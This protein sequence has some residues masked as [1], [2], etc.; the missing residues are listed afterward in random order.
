MG[1]GTTCLALLA[2]LGGPVPAPRVQGPAVAGAFYPADAQELAAVVDRLLAQAPD[3]GIPGL[4]ALVCP[5]AGYAFSGPVAAA[6]Y[7]QVRGRDFRRAI[8]LGPSHY[9][10]F[11]GAA[12]PGAEAC[13]TPLGDLRIPPGARDWG[14]PI[15]PD[16]PCRV[17]APAWAKAEARPTPFTYE[18]SVEVQLPFLQKVLPGC[19]VV[20]LLLGRT[21]PAALARTLASHVDEHTLVIASSDLSHY[22]T[23][24]RGRSLDQACVA[25]ICDLD[26]ARMARQEACGKGPILTLLHL[27]RRMGWK[28]RLLDLRSSGD[29]GAGRDSVVG[30]AAIAF[31]DP[32]AARHALAPLDRDGLSPSERALLLDLARRSLRAAAEGGPAPGEPANLT[33][34]LREDRGC[35][36]TLTRRGELRGCIGHIRPVEPLWKAVVDNARSAALEDLRF[37]PVKGAEAELLKIEVSV[38]TVPRPLV[39]ASAAD[40]AARLRPGVDGV[41]LK[42]GTRQATFLPQVWKELPRREAFLSELSLKAGGSAGMWREAGVEV[43]TYQVQAFQEE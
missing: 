30:Y 11:D 42:R 2:V 37:R 14:G 15:R 6:A 38:L 4:R 7:R 43:W 34:A 21:D 35:F 17:E 10:S 28:A 5:H 33:S 39:F 31:F 41:V 23:Y 8:V 25:A 16:P 27:A 12:I 36:V 24:D 22:L 13:R 26:P 3:L 32:P 19:E 20:P 29:A 18:H 40:L 9:A 1:L